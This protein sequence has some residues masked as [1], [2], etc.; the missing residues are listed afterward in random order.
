MVIMHVIAPAAYGGLERMVQQLAEGL[1][2][3]GHDVHVVVTV[4][5]AASAAPFLAPLADAGVQIHPIVVPAR[6]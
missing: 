6:A 2:R 4:N 5:D 1:H 3:R